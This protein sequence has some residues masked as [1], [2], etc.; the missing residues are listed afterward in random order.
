MV[1]EKNKKNTFIATCS[2]MVSMR[3]WSKKNTNKKKPFIATC[4]AIVFVR[5]WSKEK[6]K[7]KQTKHLHSHL[8][9]ILQ[10]P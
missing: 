4:R 9:C 2:A 10:W 7:T 5:M 6:N 8:Q 1:E 3:A